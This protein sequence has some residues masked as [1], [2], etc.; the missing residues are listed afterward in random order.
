MPGDQR[1]VLKTLLISLM[2]VA[3]L[4]VGGRWFYNQQLEQRLDGQ[5]QALQR[6]GGELSY[7][8]VALAPN[9]D[10]HIDELQLRLPE[11]AE[12]LS[13]ERVRVHTGGLIDFH[14]VALE[15]YN[16]RLPKSLGLSIEGLRLS[17]GSAYYRKLIGPVTGTQSRF[18][19]AGCGAR[20]GFSARDLEQ[21]G[22][23]R[24][25]LDSEWHYQLTER[26]MDLRGEMNTRQMHRLST[27]LSL[28]LEMPD[29]DLTRAGVAL[30]GSRLRALHLTYHDQG[31]TQRVMNFCQAETG[32]NAEEFQA[33]HLQAWQE[34][35]HHQG[36]VAGE[37]MVEAYRDLLQQPDHW[38]VGIDPANPLPLGL[39]LG[40]APERWLRQLELSVSVNEVPAVPVELRA[41]E[42]EA[43]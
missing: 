2:L 35:W 42:V 13:I 11:Y 14:R 31:L 39:L 20:S 10:I 4:V 8:S 43:E 21:M 41:I 9:G 12:F 22:Y 17:P 19:T 36:L 16:Q 37:D 1:G 28:A 40:A 5:A 32:L 7:A 33:R 6:L 29:R 3:A 34:A 38:R 18:T 25:V 24:L 27:R 26:G 23:T 15:L 30:L